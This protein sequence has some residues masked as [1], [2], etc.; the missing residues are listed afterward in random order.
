MVTLDNLRTLFSFD[1]F[2]FREILQIGKFARFL[3]GR[4]DDLDT[5]DLARLLD[6]DTGENFVDFA[7]RVAGD[8]FANG[9]MAEFFFNVAALAPPKRMG[10]L[11][12][13]VLLWNFVFGYPDKT[14]RN[15]ERGVAEFAIALADACKNDTMLSSPVE[16][17]VIEDSKVKGITLGGGGFVAA[18]AVICATTASA[19]LRM[20]PNLPNNISAPLRK[21]T[22]SSCCHAA[23]GVEGNP[24]PKP[25][26]TFSFL[27][28][29]RS[30]IAAYFDCTVASPLAAPPGKGLIHVYPREEYTEEFIEMSDEDITRKFIDEIRKYAPDMPEEP[31]FSRVHRWREAVFLA[32]DGVMTEMQ[33]LRRQ[34][35]P[36][37]S[38]LVLAGEY[39]SMMG[40]DN[41]LGSGV[42]AAR[43]LIERH[44]AQSPDHEDATT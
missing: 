44:M 42:E 7:A 3:K 23:F 21:V 11:Q 22:Y 10:A 29:S 16:R 28:R 43:W 27:P 17:I 41:A 18:D 9:G 34:G 32:E 2:S 25:T 5:K 37:V 13:L 39:M 33:E 30:F 36:G 1:L 35:F 19:A 31:L 40:V 38:G 12:G 26:Y 6:L 8:D 24:L 4:R 20:M 14:A 15:P